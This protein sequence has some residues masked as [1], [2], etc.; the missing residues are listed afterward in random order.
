MKSRIDTMPLTTWKI[1]LRRVDQQGYHYVAAHQKGRAPIV[2]EHIELV[3]DGRTI[4]WTVV[5]IFKDHS[6]RQGIDVFTVRVD[7]RRQEA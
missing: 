7:E 4:N 3:V 2:G 1:M 5:E 6:T